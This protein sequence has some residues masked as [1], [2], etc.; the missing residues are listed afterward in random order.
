MP[1]YYIHETFFRPLEFARKRS[2]LPAPVYN[3]LQ[4]LLKG[5]K[6]ETRFIPIRSMQFQAVV[7]SQ[8]VIFVDSQGDYAHQDGVGGRL[9]C[10][11]WQPIPAAERKSLS[12]PVPC[13]ILFYSPHL[14]T[15][16]RRLMSELPPV[17]RRL[18]QQQ[19][20]QNLESRAPRIIPLRRAT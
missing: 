15:T 4:L 8:E 2:T 11:A 13:E 3:D 7:E 5:G 6:R 19:R 17:L 14:E 12:D 9:I 18:L 20:A 10:I 16:Q 1:S